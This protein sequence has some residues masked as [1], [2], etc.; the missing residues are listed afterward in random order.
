MPPLDVQCYT[1]SQVALYWIRG[2]DKEWKPF[3]QNRVKEIRHKVHPELWHHCPG[4]SNPADLP[5]RGLTMMELSVSSLWRIGP[6]WLHTNT[7]LPLGPSEQVSMPEECAP[8]LRVKKR[9]THTLVA[10]ES[11]PDI[12]RILNIED[13]SSLRHLLRITA[14]V[15]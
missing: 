3:V 10:S 8:E 15:L 9:H 6:E 2:R 4:T 12:G 11:A 5:S 13:Y 1:D 7:R 14:R